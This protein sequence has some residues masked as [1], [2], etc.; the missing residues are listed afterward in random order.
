MAPGAQNLEHIAKALSKAIDDSPGAMM[1]LGAFYETAMGLGKKAIRSNKSKEIFETIKDTEH[2]RDIVR[3][4]R[5]KFE[6]MDLFSGKTHEADMGYTI[7]GRFVTEWEFEA[8][9]R[10]VGEDLFK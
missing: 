7:D 5:D 4:N 3:R 8:M 9:I 10:S 1:D 2:H 6:T